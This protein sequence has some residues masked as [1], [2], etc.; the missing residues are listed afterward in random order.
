MPRLSPLCQLNGGCLGCCGY[1]FISAESIQESVVKNT[2]EFNQANPKSDHEFTSFR[3]RRPPMDL[4]NGVCRNLIEEQGCFVC[5]LHPARHEGKDLREGHCDV[6]YLCSTAE[7][8]ATW[9]KAK[10]QQFILFIE[11]KKLDNLQYSISMDEG[12]LLQEFEK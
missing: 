1:D 12:K 2:Q 4:R 7:A 11:S 9:D 8:F 3:D 6:D 5:P 10:Q